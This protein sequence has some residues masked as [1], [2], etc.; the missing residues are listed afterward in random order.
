MEKAGLTIKSKKQSEEASLSGTRRY[1]VYRNYYDR[2]RHR[3]MFPLKDHRGNVCGF[4]G[5]K[6]PPVGESRPKGE[7]QEEKEAKYINTPETPIY[8]KSDLL[9]GLW[10]T[11]E[12]IKKADEA[13]LVEGELDAISSYQAG[14]KNVVAIKG[15]ALTASQVQTLARFT[16]KIIFP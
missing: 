3:L 14:V 11:K 6:I 8:H 15:S 13:I 9:Y 4:A 5:R 7:S 10:E 12:E 2:F 1:S 16:K